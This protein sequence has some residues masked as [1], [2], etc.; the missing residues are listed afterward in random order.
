MITISVTTLL[1]IIVKAII[2]LVLT[3]IIAVCCFYTDDPKRSI[4]GPII[5]FVF[6]EIALIAVFFISSFVKFVA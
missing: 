3:G 4:K 6:S 1:A 2:F 5:T